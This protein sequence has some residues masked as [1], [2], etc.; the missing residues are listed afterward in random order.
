M[1]GASQ[2]GMQCSEFDALL[3]EALDGTLAGAKLERFRGHALIR[4]QKRGRASDAGLCVGQ[5]IGT[6]SIPDVGSRNKIS[7]NGT[8]AKG[9]RLLPD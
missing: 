5:V 2:N 4:T 7:T 6:P 9:K 3:T 8:K 1:P